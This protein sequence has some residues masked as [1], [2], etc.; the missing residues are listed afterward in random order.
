MS[1]LMNLNNQLCLKSQDVVGFLFW[2]NLIV[3]VKVVYKNWLRKMTFQS[4]KFQ[5]KICSIVLTFRKE[6]IFYIPHAVRISDCRVARDLL[7]LEAPLGKLFST[8]CLKK[9]LEIRKNRFSRIPIQ[10]FSTK[11]IIFK[12]SSIFY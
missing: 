6:I 1:I 8:W 3:E 5:K 11:V 2:G 10:Y 12:P 9:I 7:L 4:T